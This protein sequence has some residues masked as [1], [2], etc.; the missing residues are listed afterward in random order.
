MEGRRYP[1]PG[2]AVHRIVIGMNCFA[3]RDSLSSRLAFAGRT[4]NREDPFRVQ[5]GERECSIIGSPRLAC[6][7]ILPNLGQCQNTL[8]LDGSPPIPC[9]SLLP[10]DLWRKH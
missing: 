1:L 9:Y 6:K 10:L 7:K 8:P 5:K 4:L 2:H 3:R